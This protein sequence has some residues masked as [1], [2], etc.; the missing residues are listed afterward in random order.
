MKRIVITKLVLAISLCFQANLCY[1]QVD[2]VGSG[3]ALN[4]NGINQYVDLGNI[5]DDLALPITVSA[6]VKLDGSAGAFPILV[7]QDNNDIY[8]GFWFFVSRTNVWLEIGDG[9][10]HDLPAFRR[11]KVATV[12]IKSEQWY[13]V[14]VVMRN[15]SDAD[16]YVN[17][18]NVGGVISG[19]SSLPMSSNFPLDVAKIGYFFSNGFSYWFKGV[20]DD[21][22]LYNIALTQNQVRTTMCKKLTGSETGLIGNWNFNETSGN[23]IIDKSPNGFNGTLINSP[24]R[25]Y[26]GAPIGDESTFLY[27]ASW[28]GAQLTMN[29]SGETVT[30]SNVTAGSHGVHT[31]VV[32]NAPTQ[33]GG[34]DLAVSTPPYFGVFVAGVA[35]GQT[36]DI[37][38]STG[39][40][41][42]DR[43]DNSFSSWNDRILDNIVNRLEFIR[44]QQPTPITA[45]L[46]V[47]ETLCP[48]TPRTLQPIANPIGYTF[49]WQDGS[50]Q[51]TYSP[52]SYGTY[53]VIAK[54][55]CATDRDSVTF[56]RAEKNQL[57][58]DLGIDKIICPMPPT[59]LKPLSE[60]NGFTFEWQD[61]SSNPTFIA[62]DYGKYWVSIT[63][64]CHVGSDT[65]TFIKAQNVL[66][67]DLGEDISICPLPP[68]TLRPLPNSTGYQFKWQDE[69]TKSELTVSGYGKYWVSITS[70]CAIGSDTIRFSKKEFSDLFIPNIITPNNDG[71][72]QH[73]IIGNRESGEQ[74]LGA[75]LEIFNRWGKKVYSTRAYENNW[76]GEGLQAGIYYY[77]IHSECIGEKKGWLT[78]KK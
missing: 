2:N 29:E 12:D 63:S 43:L 68:V 48:F 27:P 42:K 67:V 44:T 26:S 78:V 55:G 38:Y 16:I 51:S 31:Y 13:H 45:N 49:L 74:L 35:T 50:T 61:G 21:V 7:T 52:T 4:F 17:G 72:N 10:G 53:W 76:S 32:R 34:L 73:F 3:R 28:T 40:C 20:M 11:G 59:V 62:N 47:D 6:W 14:C 15:P 77:L 70:D 69:S 30:L 1:S 33:S 25:I 19:E 75:K 18:I 64:E 36:F 71:Y 39:Q 66:D 22:R 46:G 56:T 60:T 23:T 57:A 65:I 8:N 41:V 58:F 24:A 5:Y 9:L 37:S 54:K